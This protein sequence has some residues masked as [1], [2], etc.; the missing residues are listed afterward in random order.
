MTS[1][2]HFINIKMVG[3]SAECRAER[4]QFLMQT[5][6]TRDRHG[7]VDSGGSMPYTPEK[8]PEPE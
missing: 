3:K 4:F 5:V 1:L 2:K 6:L 7:G 8:K